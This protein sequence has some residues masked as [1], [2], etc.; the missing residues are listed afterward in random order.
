MCGLIIGVSIINQAGDDTCNFIFNII[1]RNL[2]ALKECSILNSICSIFLSLFIIVF[3]IFL[4]GQCSI[5]LPFIL[6]AP[7]IW[8]VFTGVGVSCYYI[9]FNY[10]GLGYFA[11]IN[12]PCYAITA[13]TIVKGCCLSTNFSNEIFISLITGEWKRQN[14]YTLKQYC[15]NFVLLL[16]PL[17]IS[18]LIKSGCY[19]LFSNLF[20]LV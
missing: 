3:Y 2:I 18:A 19:K 15:I 7:L 5:G 10:S 17:L 4:F 8:G 13:A 16:I 9:M 20:S 14:G 11:L 1:K 6:M 12:L